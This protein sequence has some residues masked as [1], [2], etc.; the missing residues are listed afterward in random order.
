MSDVKDRNR[1]TEVVYSGRTQYDRVVGSRCR[2]KA[3]VT[4]IVK[5]SVSGTPRRV[6]EQHARSNARWGWV[7]VDVPPKREDVK[8]EVVQELMEFIDGDAEN[9]PRH[10][11]VTEEDIE[12]EVNR[13]MGLEATS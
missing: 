12:D 8:K 9:G 1:C 5:Q 10:V 4:I 7:R 3:T 6:C 2:R 13:R 11:D